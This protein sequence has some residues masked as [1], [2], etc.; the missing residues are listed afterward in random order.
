MS[1]RQKKGLLWGGV[2]L[3]AVLLLVGPRLVARSD[4]AGAHEGAGG[5]PGRGQDTL[6]VTVARAEQ[7]LLE[8]AVSTTGTLLPWEA[9]E[10]R[11]EVAGRI[12]SLRF[13]EGARVGAGQTLATLDTDVLAAERAAAQSRRDLAAVQARRRRELYGIGGLARQEVDQAESEVRVLDAELARI[14]AEAARRRIVAP[15]A[16]TVGLRAV[17]VGAYV[18]PGDRLATLRVTDPLRLEFAVPERFLGRVSPGD[19]VRFT[20]AGRADSYAATVY[21][22]EPAV[23]EATRTFTVRARV[24]NAGGALQAGGFAEV[25]L[26]VD[27]VENALLVPTSA[28]TPSADSTTVWTVVDGTAVPRRVTTGARTADRIQIT[29]GLAPDAVVL[30]SGTDTVRPGQAVRTGGAFDP[31][32]VAPRARA[33]DAP[34]YRIRDGGGTTGSA[35]PSR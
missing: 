4:E 14:N 16:G 30:T 27:E 28:V 7:E 25:E 24:R 8:D 5:G 20:V 29:S 9:V 32:R 19:V 6:V 33:D 10:L 2:A 34:E 17:S 13:A 18:A 23:D 22:A 31:T 11:A 3:A 21:A 35:R 12:T 1:P 26:V 15:F